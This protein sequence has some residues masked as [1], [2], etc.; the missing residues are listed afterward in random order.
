MTSSV[1]RR[2]V[3]DRGDAQQRLGV[4]VLRVAAAP[5]SVGP[6]STISP[7]YITR[8]RSQVSA[9]TARSW[10]TSSRRQLVGARSRDSSSR[11]SAWIDDVER[12]GRLVG[13][14][15]LGLERDRDRDQ[16]ALQHAAGQLVR[17][18]V[19][20]PLGSVQPDLGEQLDGCARGPRARPSPPL[21]PQLSASWWPT[22]SD[23]LRYD[24]GSW[25]T[26]AS[27]VPRIW[28]QVPRRA[29]VELDRVASPLPS[30][31]PAARRPRRPGGQQPEHR[32]AGQRL[33]AAGLADQADGLA[34]ADLERDVADGDAGGRRR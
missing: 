1:R 5:A 20:D 23:G 33:A 18:L 27:R 32:P 26:A 11:I 12:G 19:V 31:D 7:A 24:A 25:K 3:A 9:T 4:G 8:I 21:D 13:D 17:V 29:P 28:S 16:D 34:A 15:Q 22:V 6:L 2:P 30:T 14:Q 10:V